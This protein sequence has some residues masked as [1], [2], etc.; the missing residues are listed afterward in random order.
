M[1][2]NEKGIYMSFLINSDIIQNKVNIMNLAAAAI[3]MI[4]SWLVDLHTWKSRRAFQI[5]KTYVWWLN[6]QFEA[7]NTY[8]GILVRE[9]LLRWS[10]WRNKYQTKRLKVLAFLTFQHV[11]VIAFYFN[12][13]FGWRASNRLSENNTSIQTNTSMKRPC[14]SYK[15][16]SHSCLTLTP[17]PIA[18]QPGS[19]VHGIIQAKILEWIAVPLLRGLL[20]QGP[21]LGAS[22]CRQMKAAP[23]PPGKPLKTLENCNFKYLDYSGSDMAYRTYKQ[24]INPLKLV[25]KKWS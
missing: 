7:K 5:W 21:N 24:Y 17:W 25:L 23:R 9:K 16:F 8:K 13:P 2:M 19:S 4:E 12:H 15:S 22:H 20:N 18:Y 3:I 1:R 14:L 6:R 11:D 10:A